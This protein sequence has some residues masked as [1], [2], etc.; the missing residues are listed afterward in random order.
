MHKLFVKYFVTA[1]VFLMCNAVLAQTSS[2]SNPNSERENN[3]YSKYGIGELWN[4]NNTALKSMGN[5]SSAWQDPLLINSDNPASYS[6]LMLTT[7][8]G[9]AIASTRNITAAT[10]QSYTTGTASLGY[11]CIGIPI[12]QKGGL[13]LGLRPFTKT[14]FALL[15][16]IA[17]PAGQVLRSYAGDGGLSYAYLGASYKF[18]ELSVGFN[19]GYLFGNYR[20]FTSVIGIDSLST[21]SIY[22]AQFARYTG[23]GGIY[24]KGGLMYEHKMADTDY[25][26]RIGGT[27]TLGQ[28]LNENVSSYRVSIKNLGDT[29]INDTSYAAP[30]V[31]G[32]LR[33]PVSY[34]IGVML[35][36]NDKWGFGIDYNATNW[37]GYNSSKDTAMNFGIASSNYKIALGGQFTPNSADLL[38][39]FS[40]VTYRIG[41]YYGT[42]YVRLQNIALPNYGF[43]FGGSFPYKRNTRSVARVHASFDIGRLGTT[44]NNLLKQTYVRF[45]LGLSFNEK[46]FIPRKYD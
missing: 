14:Y 39:Y 44:N 3:P 42:D 31:K 2:I 8:E 15:D 36:K 32:T 41:V 40:R 20:N 27:L 46:W 29:L 1:L 26:L 33:L 11:L 12:N 6:S 43:T 35:A 24:W 7:F 23:I 18:K 13:S 19:F 22:E 37:S 21:N 30:N 45:G 16:T 5:I 25:V 38:N 34:S 28:N 9:G 10:G 17:T 4:G